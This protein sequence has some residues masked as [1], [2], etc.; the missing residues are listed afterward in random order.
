MLREVQSTER[1]QELT[2]RRLCLLRWLRGSSSSKWERHAVIQ[3]EYPG[4][5][6]KWDMTVQRRACIRQQGRTMQKKVKGKGGME[7]TFEHRFWRITAPTR[8]GAYIKEFF[9]TDH[10]TVSGKS[11]CLVCTEL[12][13]SFFCCVQRWWLSSIMKQEKQLDDSVW[14]LEKLFAACFSSQHPLSFSL[15]SAWALLL[16]LI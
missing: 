7:W 15:S 3:E 8:S 6:W 1:T 11:S 4:E 14:L 13:H 9:L 10:L 16:H 2:W 5:M 12:A